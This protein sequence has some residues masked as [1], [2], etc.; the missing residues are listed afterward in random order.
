MERRRVVTPRVLD[1]RDAFRVPISIEHPALLIS[2]NLDGRTP[3]EDQEE[4][5]SQF[6]RLQR[7]RV[8]NAGHN[9]LEAH[10]GVQSRLLSICN[11]KDGS[12]GSRTRATGFPP[13]LIFWS[14]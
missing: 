13:L 10:P 14:R 4:V 3:V 11:G 2:G 6:T 7:W 5:A 1:L 8:E 12:G 9:V